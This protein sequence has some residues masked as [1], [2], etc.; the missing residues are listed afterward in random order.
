[1]VTQAKNPHPQW[2]VWGQEAW[3]LADFSKLLLFVITV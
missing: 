1:M 2:R 3:I